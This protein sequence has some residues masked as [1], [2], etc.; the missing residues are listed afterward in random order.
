M[1]IRNIFLFAVISFPFSTN[2]TNLVDNL[3]LS[4]KCHQLSISL[5]KLAKIETVSFC[6]EK[7]SDASYYTEHA[8]ESLISINA[9]LS[10]LYLQIAS[11]KLAYTAV[12]ECTQKTDISFFK[13]EITSIIDS[14]N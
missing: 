9:S 1:K 4:K 12:E 2:A 13:N 10:K 8:A 3:T 11:Q 6:K 14:I 7:I 5:E